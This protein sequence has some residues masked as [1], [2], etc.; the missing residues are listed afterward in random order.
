MGTR[1]FKPTDFAAPL[2]PSTCYSVPEACHLSEPQAPGFAILLVP[3]GFPSTERGGP[4]SPLSLT[5]LAPPSKSDN[6]RFPTEGRKTITCYC[7]GNTRSPVFSRYTEAQHFTLHL[8]AGELYFSCP[9][10]GIPLLHWV[11]V[12]Y[13]AGA[14][15]HAQR[16]SAP[17]YNCRR[18]PVPHQRAGTPAP[19]LRRENR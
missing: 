2:V 15:R 9:R 13:Y 3:G 10:A 4:A 6:A 18:A 16:P 14:N 5:A 17:Y 19:S 1:W 7:T 11:P 8:P 12:H